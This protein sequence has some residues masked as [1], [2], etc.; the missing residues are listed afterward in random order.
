MKLSIANPKIADVFVHV[1][2]DF[3]IG[4]FGSEAMSGTI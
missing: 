1:I 2:S 4:N 3:L